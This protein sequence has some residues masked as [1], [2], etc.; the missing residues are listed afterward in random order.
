[1]EGNE[2]RSIKQTLKHIYSFSFLA[3][4]GLSIFS[5]A[6]F[7]G[8]QI[9]EKAIATQ[10]VPKKTSLKPTH[11]PKQYSDREITENA[12]QTDEKYKDVVLVDKTSLISNIISSVIKTTPAEDNIPERGTWLWT[13]V[14][15]LTP[16]YRMEI[17][18]SAKE[19]DINVIYL[20]VDSYL[21]IFTMPNGEEKEK[22]KREFEENLVSFI[23]EANVNGIR[24]DAEA[25][26]Q[27][28]AEDGNAYKPEVVL[29]Y[30]INFNKTH[31]QKFRGFQYDVEVYLLPEYQENKRV[32]LYSF[33]S[34]VDQTVVKLNNTDLLLSVVIP[35]FYD[36]STDETPQYSYRGE[37]GYTYSHLLR[38]LERRKGSKLIVMSYRNYAT[39]DDSTVDVSIDEIV[40]ANPYSTKVVVAQETGNFP[41]SYITFHNTTKKYY[42]KQIGLIESTLSEHKSFGGIATH[43]ANSFFELK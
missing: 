8:K 27:N 20:S 32:T 14:K 3:F 18:V 33:I 42:D 34:L 1:M 17:I 11:Y 26:W 40:M 25:G 10:S 29:D 4:L 13:P 39:G 41:P 5:Y 30:V 37:K 9:E 31:K 15:F 12:K 24:V 21:D 6:L 23:A 43:Y 16:D 2:K 35:E 36:G 38:V 28:W 7:D 22:A 19:R